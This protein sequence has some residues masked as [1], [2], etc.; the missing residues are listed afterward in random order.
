M[1]IPMNALTKTIEI[2]IRTESR[3]ATKY[4][5][6]KTIVRASRKVFKGKLS[7][8]NIEI[9][10]TI[11]KPNYSEREF[12]KKCKKAGEPFPIKKIQLKLIK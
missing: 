10:L 6:E 4:L 3:T 5:D 7:K 12:I 9:I 11:G 2:L 8:G 1:K